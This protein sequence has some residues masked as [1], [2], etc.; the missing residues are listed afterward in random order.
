MVETT[1]EIGDDEMRIGRRFGQRTQPQVT[2]AA[3]VPSK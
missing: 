2:D 1:H 3:R